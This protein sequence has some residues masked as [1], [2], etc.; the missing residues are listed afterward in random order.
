LEIGWQVVWRKKMIFLLQSSNF[1]FYLGFRDFYWFNT[2]DLRNHSI[3]TKEKTTTKIL[4]IITLYIYTHSFALRSIFG[5]NCGWR[6]WNAKAMSTRN[7]AIILSRVRSLKF[8][9]L[10]NFQHF[11]LLRVAFRSRRSQ[12]RHEND[13]SKEVKEKNL[14]ACF[15]CYFEFIFC[16]VFLIPQMWPPHEFYFD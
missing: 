16:T 4:H 2:S 13:N 8:P 6:G 3:W 1:C 7:G 10:Q 11:R 14:I 15:Q 12:H 9:S 5:W